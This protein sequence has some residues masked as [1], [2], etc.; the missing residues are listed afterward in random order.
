MKTA[1]GPINSL[2]YWH[3]QLAEIFTEPS[4]SFPQLHALP[5]QGLIFWPP[6]KSGRK[7][8]L[9]HNF[10]VMHAC[11]SNITQTMSGSSVSAWMTWLAWN[12]FQKTNTLGCSSWAGVQWLLK[13]KV[14]TLHPWANSVWS[15][16]DFCYGTFTRHLSSLSWCKVRACVC[17]IVCVLM[18]L[19]PSETIPPLTRTLYMISFGPKIIFYIFLLCCLL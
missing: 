19:I 6:L 7:P 15:L 11:K 3:L 12:E 2:C 1:K 16:A 8:L 10:C 17:V 13:W 5:C 4:T 9:P 18:V 14:G